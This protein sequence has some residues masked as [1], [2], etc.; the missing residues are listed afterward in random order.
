MNETKRLTKFVIESKP[1][2]NFYFEII[3]KNES[4]H[5]ILFFFPIV[6]VG[7]GAIVRIVLGH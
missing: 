1:V 4:K 3:N 7:V 5:K 2:V 6:F